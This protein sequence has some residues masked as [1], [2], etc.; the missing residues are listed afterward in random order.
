MKIPVNAKKM[1][2]KTEEPKIED[3]K[4]DLEHE[5]PPADGTPDSPSAGPTAP[6]V[7]ETPLQKLQGE[8]DSLF[9]RLARLQA[10]FENYRKRAAKEQQDFRD[11]AVADAVK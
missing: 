1:N 4:L 8:R 3:R 2:T 7:A 10:E 9:D 6:T 5:L 11:Y